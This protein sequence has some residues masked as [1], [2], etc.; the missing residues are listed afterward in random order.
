MPEVEVSRSQLIHRPVGEVFE[1]VR[2]FE[3]WPKWS[4]WLKAAPGFE[5]QFLEEAFSWEGEVCGKGR[6]RIFDVVEQ[7]LIICELRIQKPDKMK[8]AVVMRFAERDG[9]TLVTWS[10]E[11]TLPFYLFW[12]A[13]RLRNLIE[14]DYER[15]LRMLQDL[16]ETGV[17]SS[18]V[19][20]PGKKTY[21]FFVGV[22]IRRKVSMAD[23]AEQVEADR[24]S[25]V[26]RYPEGEAVTVYHKWSF[27]KG[28][29]VYLAGVRLER[30]PGVVADGMELFEFP[31]GDVFTVRHFGDLRHLANGWA[32]GRMYLRAKKMKADK[33][34]KPF[35]VYE[36]VEGG[37]PVVRICLPLKG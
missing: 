3:N 6:M 5:L 13:G 23:F 30:T 24:R 20:V 18:R 9:A 34:A 8:A 33:K 19:E 26:E 7:E 29:V 32:A 35:E 27:K 36:E 16:A 2:H 15:G 22:G 17:V 12:M 14:R 37:D 31:G 4:P 25:V 10:L 1:L 28:R 11:T 21:A